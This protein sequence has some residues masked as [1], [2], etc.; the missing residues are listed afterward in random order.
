MPSSRSMLALRGLCIAL[1]LHSIAESNPVVHASTCI[2]VMHNT[3]FNYAVHK[4]CVHGAIGR[5]WK[6]VPCSLWCLGC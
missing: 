6:P 1:P 3:N 2:N 5:V 4:V